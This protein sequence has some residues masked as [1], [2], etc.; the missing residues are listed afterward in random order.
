MPEQEM[1]ELKAEMVSVYRSRLD[2]A[3]VI[4]IDTAAYDGRIR[5]NLNDGPIYDG[6]P[7]AHEPPGPY[8]DIDWMAVHVSEE[9]AAAVLDFFDGRGSRLGH[10][11]SK[12]IEAI[13]SADDD[14]TARLGSG[15]R[16]WVRAVGL[17]RSDKD[18][19]RALAGQPGFPGARYTMGG[20]E[21]QSNGE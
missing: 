6:D 1:S 12:L 10:F 9:V 19:L 2:T 17:W 18:E 21:E 20:S 3:L 5:V 15:F 8:L 7:D 14:N 4:Q 16:D 11:E 13:L